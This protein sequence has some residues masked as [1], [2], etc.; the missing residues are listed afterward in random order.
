M[1]VALPQDSIPV[2]GADG[3]ALDSNDL[4]LPR[5]GGFEPSSMW[6]R[7]KSLL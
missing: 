5:A 1:V 4:V 2:A 3:H 7:I 6:E